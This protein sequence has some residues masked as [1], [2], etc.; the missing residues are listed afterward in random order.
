MEKTM[1]KSAMHNSEASLEF[2]DLRDGLSDEELKKVSGLHWRDGKERLRNDH[3][4]KDSKVPMTRRPSALQGRTFLRFSMKE[5]DSG[6]WG[7]KLFVASS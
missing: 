2:R 7:S 4:T 3:R 6:L 1:S 5:T